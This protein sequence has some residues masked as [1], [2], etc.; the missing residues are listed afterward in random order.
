MRELLPPYTGQ[1]PIFE[2]VVVVAG[3]L[4]VLAACTLALVLGYHWY[5]NRRERIRAGLRDRWE[6]LL[7]DVMAGERAPEELTERIEPAHRDIF[8]SVL[9]RY[10]LVV[11]GDVVRALEQLADPFLART[12][13]RLSDLEPTVRARSAQILGL[14]G[15]A[16]RVDAVER[17]V[18]DSSP[19]VGLT[20]AWALVRRRRSESY[21]V[22]LDELARFASYGTD[23]LVSLCTAMGSPALPA[24]R[25]MLVDENRSSIVRTIAAE[26]LRWMGDGGSSDE[27]ARLLRESE[28]RELRAAVL[29]LLRRIGRSE[30]AEAVREFAGHEDE[31]LRLHALAALGRLGDASDLELLRAGLEDPSTWVARRA[32]IAL[33]ELGFSGVL[34]G[35]IES[36]H[37]RSELARQM[38]PAH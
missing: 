3:V 20:A 9:I 33:A 35:L 30:H 25:A 4:T 37:H 7:L 24:L 11:E 34:E 2:V 36:G 31:V 10:A 14:L 8:V 26:A 16:N 5:Q 17:A 29:R 38:L 1:G 23:Q 27:A 18:R 21:S 32:A 13:Q 19:L 12:E 22:I 6:P 28:D 15:G